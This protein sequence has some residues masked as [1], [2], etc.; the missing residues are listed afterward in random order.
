[1]KNK[2]NILPR[3]VRGKTENDEKVYIKSTSR[4]KYQEVDFRGRCLSNLICS[5]YTPFA[6][7]RLFAE[8]DCFS[9]EEEAVLIEF[10]VRNIFD[11]QQV[12]DAGVSQL[13]IH[14]G[15]A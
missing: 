10:E 6:F 11:G 7:S 2:A 1:M 15:Q 3:S 5:C 14:C 8:S 4:V 12:D 9:V 13:P